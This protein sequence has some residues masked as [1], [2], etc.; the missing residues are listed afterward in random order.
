MKSTKSSL[1]ASLTVMLLGACTYEISLG[2]SGGDAQRVYDH[3]E[4]IKLVTNYATLT[5]GEPEAVRC[6][7][8]TQFVPF[9]SF[10]C[11]VDVGGQTGNIDVRYGLFWKA[12]FSWAQPVV[13]STT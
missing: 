8:R 13:P 5:A 3:G 2:G 4:I 12:Y 10:Q 6:P 9:D 7:A 1:L 11:E